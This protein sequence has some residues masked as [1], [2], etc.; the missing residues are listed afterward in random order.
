M[1]ARQV[2]APAGGFS[3]LGL[4]L[5]VSP[6]IALTPNFALTTD[7]V[8]RR[9]PGGDKV[10]VSAASS[11]LLD[12]DVTLHSLDLDGALSIRACAGAS[13]AVRECA[14]SNGGWPFV[15]LEPGSDPKGVSIR[16]YAPDKS[17]GLSIEV[18]EPGRYEL[19]GAGVLTKLGS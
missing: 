10:K 11:L 19:S 4:G 6:A 12:G 13:V 3:A 5:D 14:V 18:S 9:V 2:A 1:C 8:I 16:G 17:G 15:P 7:E